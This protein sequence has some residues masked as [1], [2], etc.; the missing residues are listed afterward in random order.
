MT[1]GGTSRSSTAAGRHT[2]ARLRWAARRLELRSFGLVPEHF[3]AAEGYRGAVAIAAPLSVAV[4]SGN[5]HLAWAVFA[6]FWTC[7]CDAPGTHR[8]RR[9]LLAIFVCCGA[10]VAFLGSWSASLAPSAGLVAGPILVALCMIGAAR[11]A[12]GGLV[13]TLLAVVAVVAAGFP[14]S[15]EIAFVQATAFLPDPHGLIC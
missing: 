3:N 6:A 11:I 12:Y 8:Q 9:R 14:N 5:G 10:I 13:G 7:L 4:Y 1:S 15:L 2:A